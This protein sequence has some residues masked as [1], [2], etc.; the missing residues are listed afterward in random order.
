M[1]RMFERGVV[2]KDQIR[3]IY[4]SK[5]FPTT[6]YGMVYNLKP[7]AGRQDEGSLLHL[8]VGGL[9]AQEGIQ[10]RRPEIPAD[11][12]QEALGGDR[13]IDEAIGVKY[14]CKG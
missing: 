12:L 5:T 10:E 9:G 11:Q 14:D 2:K 7:E 1:Y 8:P 3:S 6:G 13:E 4:K